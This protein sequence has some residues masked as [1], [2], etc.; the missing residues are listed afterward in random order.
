MDLLE[1]LADPFF[2][3]VVGKRE[4]ALSVECVEPDCWFIDPNQRSFDMWIINV[5]D[6]A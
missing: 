6:T 2:R 3:L 5:P 1:R 4:D